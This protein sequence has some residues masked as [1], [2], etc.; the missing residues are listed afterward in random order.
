MSRIYLVPA[1]IL[2]F[3]LLACT[4]EAPPPP[5]VIE[6]NSVT[7][8]VNQEPSATVVEDLPEAKGAPE[9][10]PKTDPVTIAPEKSIPTEAKEGSTPKPRSAAIQPTKDTNSKEVKPETEAI[11]APQFKEENLLPPTAST[12]SPVPATAP[13][14]KAPPT[15]IQVPDHS[16]W[17]SLLQTHVTS[18]GKVNY[19][20]FKREEAKLDAYL[21]SLSAGSPNAEWSRQ[22]AMAYWINAYNAFTIKRILNDYPL[23]SIMDLDG[24]DPWKVKWI[25]LGGKKY[26]LNN[27]EH[28]ILRPKYKDA[29]IH[30]AVNCA[31][32]SCPPIPNKAFTA[33]NLNSMLQNSAR[34]F[35]R[36]SAYNQ[37]KG[38]IKVSKI[39]D[40]YGEDFGDLRAYLN[41]Y[42]AEPI[43]ADKKIGFKDYDWGLNKQ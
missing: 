12:A 29:R 22:E 32:T 2:S 7:A 30:F 1:L 28:D 10:V 13:T 36:N 3:V 25:D 19:A 24:G 40:W 5:T 4:A 26:S 35:I 41:K 37:T 18:T 20:G 43:P 31:A 34:K 15:L 33:A 14:L 17:N 16:P 8:P 42:L 23:K 11:P 9:E 21:A 6:D 38:D 39:F 27:I